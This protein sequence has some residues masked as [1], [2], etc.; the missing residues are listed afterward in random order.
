VTEVRETQPA[1]PAGPPPGWYREYW[2]G[3][4]LLALA[5]IALVI[6]IIWLVASKDD[7]KNKTTVPNVVGM[8]QVDAANR[9]RAQGLEP[10]IAY[11]TSTVPRGQVIAETPGA[12]SRLKKGQAVVLDVSR[13]PTQTATTPTTTAKTTTVTKTATVAVTTT[14]TQTQTRAS[15]VTQPTKTV[16]SPTVT[17]PPTTAAMPDVVGNADYVQAVQQVANAGL[18]PQTYPVASSEPQGTVVGQNPAAG[19][20]APTNVPVRLNVSLGPGT[21]S[22]GPLPDL[23]GLKAMDALVKC[24]SA[25]YTCRIVFRSAPSNSSV[26]KVLAQQPAAGTNAQGLTQITLYVGR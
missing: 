23:T 21:R 2:W 1:G 26:G 10:G 25:R 12:G 13:P 24:A 9:I 20:Q 16:T 5:A 19:T 22:S 17:A 14:A 15:T 7:N 4:L 11:K 3:L 18:L 8:Q 6:V